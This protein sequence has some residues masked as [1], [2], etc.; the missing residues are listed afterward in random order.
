M[1]NESTRERLAQENPHFRALQ[2]KHR[3]LGQR[4]DEL[5]AN[6]WLSDAEQLEEVK[7]KKMKLAIKDEME[8]ML[9]ETH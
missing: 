9:R 5:Q 2:D 1:G 4:L 8:G 6:R 7:L 3:K